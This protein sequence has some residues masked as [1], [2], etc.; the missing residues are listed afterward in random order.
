MTPL[1]NK[2]CAAC[3]A[4]HGQGQ[5]QGQVL[6]GVAM[7]T[8]PV[9]PTNI[10]LRQHRQALLY[11]KLPDLRAPVVPAHQAAYLN[12]LSHLVNEQKLPQED[13]KN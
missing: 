10:S 5:G 2:L 11:A 7:E 4:R 12:L 8:F 9:P 6:L 13:A 1:L 3:T